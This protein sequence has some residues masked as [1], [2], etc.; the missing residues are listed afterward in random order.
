MSYWAL[1]IL[2]KWI[3]VLNPEANDCKRKTQQRCAFKFIAFHDV[4]TMPR[5]LDT[6]GRAHILSYRLAGD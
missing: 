5:T 2:S 6:V 4:T 1:L 3:N